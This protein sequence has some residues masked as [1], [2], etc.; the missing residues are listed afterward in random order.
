MHEIIQLK[1]ILK[2]SKPPIWRRV[3]IHKDASF[4]DL[5]NVIQSVM[6]WENCHLWEFDFKNAKIGLSNNEMQDFSFNEVEIID[7]E[8]ITLDSCISKPKEKINYEYDFGDGWI[9]EIIVEKFL[10]KEKG[11]A[12]PI[13][14]KG[15]LNGPP[16]DCGGIWGYYNLL[17]SIKDKTHP[18]HKDM[19]EWIGGEYDEN[20]FDLEEINDDLIGLH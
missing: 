10:P 14:I 6:G 8:E 2:Y 12:Y 16:E 5:H 19:L 3:L 11:T 4:H 1:I 17:E 9:H 7:A 18:D 13:C 20:Y 15:K